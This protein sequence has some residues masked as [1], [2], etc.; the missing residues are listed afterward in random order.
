MH[1]LFRRRSGTGLPFTGPVSLR[2]PRCRPR[3]RRRRRFPRSRSFLSIMA[4]VSRSFAV[5]SGP[6]RVPRPCVPRF[7]ARLPL[8]PGRAASRT[9]DRSLAMFPVRSPHGLAPRLVPR[10]RP[11]SAAMM[12][13][14]IG[15]MASPSQGV[16]YFE[17]DG[18]Y[19]KTTPR[20]VRRAPGPARARR[21]SGYPTRSIP[22]SSRRFSKAKSRRV[23]NS[24]G[25]TRK[26]RFGRTGEKKQ[27]YGAIFVKGCGAIMISA[28]DISSKICTGW[29]S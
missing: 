5:G 18:Y 10:A 26:A 3:C 28:G 13:A 21:R 8:P 9:G 19:A 27:I 29:R 17:R 15:K 25:G 20:T 12:V 7:R 11:A 2:T 1:R 4:V 24:G 23:R 22:R 16:S 14:L 6:R